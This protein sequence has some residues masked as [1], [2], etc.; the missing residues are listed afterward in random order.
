M[1]TPRLPTIHDIRYQNSIKVLIRARKDSGLSQ[2][3]L[4][5]KMG[6]SQPDI[7]KIERFE[8]R[9]D[10]TEFMD[11]LYTVSNGDLEILNKIWNEICEC[12]NR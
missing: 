7:S 4:A 2:L 5:L 6:L 11:V 1:Q 9:L 3:D 10:V 8:R 12:H